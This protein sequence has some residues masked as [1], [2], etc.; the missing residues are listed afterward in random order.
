M[1]VLS[2]KRSEEIVIG[3]DVKVVVVE[4]RDGKV[5]LGITAPPAVSIH[6]KEVADAI[7]RDRERRGSAA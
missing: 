7:A 5:R 2:R 1:L 4:I 6:R 3:N